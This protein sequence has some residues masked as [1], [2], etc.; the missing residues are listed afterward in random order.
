MAMAVSIFVIHALGDAIA[1]PLIGIIADSGG[2]ERAVLVVP[3]AVV[4][5]GLLWMATAGFVKHEALEIG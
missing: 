5:C 2:L 1:P 3:A 4:A